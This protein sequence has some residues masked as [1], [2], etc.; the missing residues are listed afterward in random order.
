[1]TPQHLGFAPYPLKYR[2]L[3]AITALVVIYGGIK[4]FTDRYSIVMDISEFRC[5]NAW[6]YLLDK[7]DKNVSVG[8]LITIEGK[9]VPILPDKY[10]YTKMIAGLD[11]DTVS[12]NGLYT[13][14][15]NKKFKRYTPVPK[16]YYDIK[17]E[18]KLASN[19]TVSTGKAFLIGDQIKSVDSRIVGLADMRYLIGKTYVLF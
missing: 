19:W 15:D 7:K 3:M 1:M 13:S 16:E 11:K 14:N 9:G 4:A 6:V 18:K 10:R 17:K 12:F 5:L 8:D 2:I